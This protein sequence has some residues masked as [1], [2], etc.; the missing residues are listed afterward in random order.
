MRSMTGQVD[1]VDHLDGLL[2]KLLSFIVVYRIFESTRWMWV[3][4]EDD[5]TGICA[6][7]V[8]PEDWNVSLKL[9]WVV[10]II[11]KKRCWVAACLCLNFYYLCFVHFVNF[12]LLN[13]PGRAARWWAPNFCESFWLVP[14]LNFGESKECHHLIFT[15]AFHF[16]R[17]WLSKRRHIALCV[18]SPACKWLAIVLIL[19][20]YYV[21]MHGY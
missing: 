5:A 6:R 12:A 15:L 8:V 14:L 17:F 10:L 16:C 11:G 13:G 9:L 4:E 1:A 20:E 2:S 3:K 21:C 7:N 18:S 19:G